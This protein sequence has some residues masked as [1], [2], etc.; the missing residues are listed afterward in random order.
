[1]VLRMALYMVHKNEL[2]CSRGGVE[3]QVERMSC[4]FTSSCCMVTRAPVN[5]IVI[6]S[7]LI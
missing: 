7:S 6:I 5:V 1:M 3:C 4:Y 2:Y